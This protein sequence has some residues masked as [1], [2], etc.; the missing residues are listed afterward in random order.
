MQLA[1]RKLNLT[2]QNL[3]DEIGFKNIYNAYTGKNIIFGTTIPSPL[4][5]RDRKPSF[6]IHKSTGIYRDF[7]T[8]ESGD[9]IRFVRKITGYSFR[10]SLVHIAYTFAVQDNYLLFQKDIDFI[11]GKS[12]DVQEIQDKLKTFDPIKRAEL[13]VKARKVEAHDREYWRDYNIKLSDLKWARIFP[14]SE[15]TLNGVRHIADRHAYAYVELKDKVL[16]LKVYQ[17][18]NRR[19]KWRSNMSFDIWE[20]WEQHIEKF[21]ELST[22]GNGAPYTVICASRKDALALKSLYRHQSKGNHLSVLCLQGEG[23]NIKPS[24]LDVLRHTSH[25]KICILYD[26]DQ[27]GFTQSVKLAAEHDLAN[28]TVNVRGYHKK[29]VDVAELV[30]FTRKEGKEKLKYI[31]DEIFQ[32]IRNACNS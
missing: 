8:G 7:A 25:G 13:K 26:F 22:T 5:E 15:F 29:A 14:I 12:I 31:A 24:A 3:I 21:N 17:P 4:R 28:I 1:K 2:A 27:T 10:E 9:V 6:S 20:L 32:I 30:Q 16:S 18:F 11:N 19:M 23:A